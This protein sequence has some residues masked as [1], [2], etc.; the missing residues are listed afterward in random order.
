MCFPWKSNYC[1]LWYLVKS[2]GWDSQV[3]TVEVPIILDYVFIM[4]TIFQ[5]QMLSNAHQIWHR[6]SSDLQ[7]K[8]H[9]VIRLVI[10]CPSTANQNQCWS[11]QKGSLSQQQFDALT[12][13]LICKLV[14][15]FWGCPKVI[16]PLGSTAMSKSLHR[17]LGLSP[18]KI[19]F[20]WPRLD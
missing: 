5:F 10:I 9:K 4:F 8:P 1:V 16:W 20:G 15:Q 6:W 11:R 13:N 14:N 12:Q 2:Q 3:E 19:F 17:R 7:T 18:T